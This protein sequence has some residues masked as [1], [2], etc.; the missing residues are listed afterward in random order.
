MPVSVLIV[1]DD[2]LV[3]MDMG[4]VV[5]EAGYAVV[6]PVGRACEALELLSTQGCDLALLDAN[7][8]AVGG[9]IANVAAALSERGIPFAFVTGYAREALPPPYRDVH[10]LEKPFNSARLLALIRELEAR[11][12]SPLLRG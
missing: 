8:G 10:L 9:D 5:S 6:G 4:L 7:L 2:T 1:E 11:G 3:A 12:P